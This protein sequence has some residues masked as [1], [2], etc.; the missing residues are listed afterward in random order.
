MLRE[1]T[2]RVAQWKKNPKKYRFYGN[3]QENI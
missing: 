1:K 3:L 2:L